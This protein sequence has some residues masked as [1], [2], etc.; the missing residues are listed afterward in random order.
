VEFT[1]KAIRKAR[2]KKKW[3][4]MQISSDVHRSVHPA[5]AIT[6]SRILKKLWDFCESAEKLAF[7][8]NE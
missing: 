5:S 8:E 7:L 1:A 4:K 6:A 3:W 2:G